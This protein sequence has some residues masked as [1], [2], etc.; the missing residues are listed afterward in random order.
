M[1]KHIFIL[2]F[3]LSCEQKNKTIIE[4]VIPSN[5]VDV[6]PAKIPDEIGFVDVDIL[7]SAILLDLNTLNDND[8]LNAR[9]LI[10]CDEFNQGNFNKKQ[11]N[12]AQNKLLNSISS[13]SS[14]S[15]AKQL[16]NVPCVARFDIEDFGITRNQINAIA[17]QFL[18][19]RIDSLTTRFQQIQFLTQSLNPYFFT[20]DFSVTTLG[21]DDLTKENNIYYTLIDQPFG[22]DD[23]FDS[24]GVNVQNEA[25]AERLIMT[26]IGSSSQIALQKSRGVQIAEAD[27]LFVMTTYDSSLENQDDHFTNPFTV[28]IANAQGVRRTNKIFTDNAQEHLYFLKNGFLAGRL[29]GAG[30]NAEFEAPN[31]VVINTAAASRQLSPT[32]HIGSCIGCHTQPFIRYNDQL[33]N[34]LKTSANFD[35]NERNLGQ[36]FFSQER[37]EEAAELMNE[38]YQDALKKIGAQGN[39][40]WVH[41]KL[42]FP[43]RVEQTAE[44]VC[45]MLLLPLDECLNRIRGSAVSGGVFGNLLN[46]GKVSLPVLSENFRQLVIDVQAFEDGG[47]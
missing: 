24:L 26:A 45:G 39:V 31:T 22:L 40:D 10:S 7:E 47:L 11:I 35:A 33:E 30:G 5:P 21:A 2:F 28:E 20:H 36:V 3:I 38:A 14:V 12:W 41:E 1:I 23:F 32:I 13:E 19:L 16:D 46:G 27:E 25:D 18:L 17:S 37:T 8:R 15:K 9:Y 29:N 4:R 43:L 6:P 34:H 42:I 44:R